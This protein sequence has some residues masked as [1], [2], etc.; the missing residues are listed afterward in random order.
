MSL[1]FCDHEEH[2]TD[3]ADEYVEATHKECGRKRSYLCAA[4][5]CETCTPL[6]PEPAP[7]PAS[8]GPRLRFLLRPQGEHAWCLVDR[9]D[10]LRAHVEDGDGS[11]VW[12]VR[13][14][15]MTDAEV[16]AMGEFNGW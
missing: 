8:A 15:M 5:A 10:D 11:P 3:G 7:E 6:A 14:K 4:H 13:T 1:F 9:W 2:A 12:E 16:E